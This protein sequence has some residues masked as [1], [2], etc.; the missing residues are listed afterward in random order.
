MSRPKQVIII[1]DDL[2]NTEGHKLRKGKLIAQGSHA[3]MGVILDM[4]TS[5]ETENGNTLTLDIESDSA[6]DTW[7]NDQFTKIT[8]KCNSEEVLL[9][10]YEAAEIAGLPV[11]LITD[12]GF[13]EFGGVATNTCIAIGPGYPEDIDPITKGLSLL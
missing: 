10:L 1:R 3:S 8:L 4:M 13:T 2:R 11:K 9:A 7:I 12:S 6:L 5:K